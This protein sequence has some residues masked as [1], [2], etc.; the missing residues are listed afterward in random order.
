MRIPSAA[1]TSEM[2]PRER[3]LAAFEHRETDRVP[4][5]DALN[6]PALYRAKLGCENFFSDG[7]P[8]VRLAKAIGFD[9]CLVYESTYTGLISQRRDWLDDRRFRDELGVG[10]MVDPSSWPLAF[11]ET[12]SLRNRDDWRKVTLPDPRE[13]WRHENIR[14]AIAAAHQGNA[15]DL[16]VVAGVRSAFAVLYISMGVMDLS[17]SLYEDPDL[18]REMSE[19]I[20]EFWTQSALRAVELGADAVFIANDMGMNDHTIIAPHMIRSLFMPALKTQIQ[21]IRETGTRVILHT[22]GN[23]NAILPD[24]VD[25]GIDGLNNLQ[26]LSG[27]D[28]ADIKR[29]FGDRLTLIGNVDSTNIMSGNDP[30]RVES[31]VIETIRKASPGGGHILA[32]DHSLHGGIPVSNIERFIAAAKKWGGYPLSLPDGP[33]RGPHGTHRRKERSGPLNRQVR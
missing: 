9:A 24:L 28:I 19:A 26:V 20:C 29:D 27:M 16:A 7:E 21:T 1:S 15:D 23:V 5:F 4:I 31:A 12:P 30:D 11:P 3:F 13:P 2:T 17:M 32:T 33:A 18:I 25:T 6:S 10:Y 8:T 22:C 14:S